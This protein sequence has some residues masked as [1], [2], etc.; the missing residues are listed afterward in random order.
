LSQSA[1]RNT[2]IRAARG[3]HL[4]LLDVDDRWQPSHLAASLE[5]LRESQAELA[6][7]TVATFDDRTE[8]VNG[9]WGPTARDLADFP[10]SLFRH[11][12]ITPATVVFRRSIVERIGL[13]EPNL[14]PC[15][16]LDYWIRCAAAGIRFTH[17][18]GCHVLY[19]RNN[20]QAET[21]GTCRMTEAFARV[22]DKH[23]TALENPPF[24]Y[25]RLAA[26][27][28]FSAAWCHATTNPT[29]DRT[30]DPSRAPL[31]LRRACE[32]H[33]RKAKY[34]IHLELLNACER[35]N[36]SFLRHMF[37]RCFRP[38]SFIRVGQLASH[39]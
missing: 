22:I 8:L 6:H 29:Q 26:R 13:F 9:I 34:W 30:A 38:R 20:A 11:C 7:S 18:K 36:S 2:A 28:Y 4:A 25:Y 17:V 33:R 32:V 27:V 39:I 23:K 14:C 35:L 10:Y 3:T 16:D 5:A 19:R 31:L 24:E 1:A 21:S 37:L 12:F 15:E